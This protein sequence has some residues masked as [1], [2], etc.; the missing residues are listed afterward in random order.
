MRRADSTLVYSIDGEFV[1]KFGRANK[2]LV[3]IEDDE[4]SKGETCLRLRLT[5]KTITMTRRFKT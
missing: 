5:Q 2:I 4:Y 3:D 1:I